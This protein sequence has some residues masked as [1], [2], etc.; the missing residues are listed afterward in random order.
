MARQCETCTKC[1]DGTL[2][3]NINGHEMG[4]GKPCYYLTVGKG[5]NIYEKR[6]QDPCKR[7][8][9][10]WISDENIPDFMKPENSNCILD[11]KEENKIKYLRLTEST[12]PY[13]AEVLS[14]CIN[15]AQSNNLNFAWSINK[16]SYYIKND[17][18]IK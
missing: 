4:F 11:Y 12:I 16:K 2:S 10:A 13:T 1:C 7:Y 15:Y 17:N 18:S 6:P 14:W 3:G 5:C 9:C 8:E